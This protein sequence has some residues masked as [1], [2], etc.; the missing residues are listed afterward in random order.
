[1]TK[2]LTTSI[3]LILLFAACTVGT[4][5]VT[6]IFH[7]AECEADA[8]ELAWALDSYCFDT[9]AG[10]PYC[11][12]RDQGEL[13]DNYSCLCLGELPEAIELERCLA[14]DD[15]NDVDAWLEDADFRD[16]LCGD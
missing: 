4:P 13:L 14:Y 7:Q 12:C 3:V 8:D 1:M 2:T 10:G 15:R 6:D 11:A 5:D 9:G 16:M